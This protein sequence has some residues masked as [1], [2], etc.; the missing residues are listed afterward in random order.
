MPEELIHNLNLSQGDCVVDCTLGGGGHAYQCLQR[1]GPNGLLLGID[2]DL[3]A[4]QWC[5]A[6]FRNEIKSGNVLLEHGKFSDLA[7]FIP[8][9]RLNGRVKAIYADVGTSSPQFDRGERG[10]SFV[11]DG[12]LDMRMDQSSGEITAE[13]VINEFPESE[14]SR[15][16][17]L[18]G[19][20]P[21]CR[22]FAKKIVE[23][24]SVRPFQ[25][26]QDLSAFIMNVNPYK[27]PSIKHP[28]TRIFQALRI[29]VN[30]EINE[31]KKLILTSLNLLEPKGR[32]AIIS[33][34]SLE[35]REVK[36]AF[37]SW[38]GKL[39]SDAPRDLQLLQRETEPNLGKKAHIIK[40]FPIVPSEKEIHANP[41]ARSAKLRIAEK[42]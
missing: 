35:D 12:P 7:T 1:I 28:A 36:K 9:H 39:R 4:L 22:Y 19:E 20:E 26:T 37:Q 2:R 40:P 41:R 33:F 32:I 38:A 31:I 27:K 24:R 23:R 34:H 15:I 13:K 30:D 21:K 14:L 42:L 29:V 10:F 25:T 3:D 17:Q 8:K 18:Y 16:F 5:Q 11:H 6:R